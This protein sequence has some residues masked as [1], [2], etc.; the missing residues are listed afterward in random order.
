[1]FIDE[2][3]TMHRQGDDR[4]VA[5]TP[6]DSGRGDIFGGQVAGQALRAGTLTVGEAYAP[7]SIHSYFMRRGNPHLPL[8][9]RV[10]RIRDGRTYANRRIQVWQDDREIFEMAASFHTE[11]PGR[12]YE[13]GMPDGVPR[14]DEI[15]EG[16][17]SFDHG[18]GMPLPFEIRNVDVPA[19]LVRWWGRFGDPVS[20]DP[21]VH[22]SAL[23][24]ASDMRA[25]GAAITAVGFDDGPPPVEPD[26]GPTGNFGSLD[27]SVW[28][29][30]RPN[31]E[32]WFLCDYRPLVVADSRGTI[33]GGIFDEDGNRL[34]SVAQ[35][36]F[37]KVFDDPAVQ[38]GLTPSASGS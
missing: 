38:A 32:E 11:E 28:F 10:D 34:A 9:I 23:L 33:V 29:H 19:P 35:E 1:V 36:M 4:F 16:A 14:P 18:F 20:S 37:L 17:G 25:G 3:M 24:Y 13:S 22:Y 31:V 30:R 21:F 26:G 5:H 8:D 12:S 6:A 15:D 7:N 2:I 27:H